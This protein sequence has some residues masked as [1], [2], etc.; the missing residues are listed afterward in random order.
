MNN[1]TIDIDDMINNIFTNE[2]QDIKSI[3]LSFDV[4]DEYELFKILVDILTHGLKILFGDEN[5]K[6]DINTITETDFKTIEKYFNSFGFDI[7]YK[8]DIP[9]DK[10]NIDENTE[11]PSLDDSNTENEDDGK[12]QL[13][14]YYFT[15]K[16]DN[17]KYEIS[18]DYL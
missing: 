9:L 16:T 12:N 1:I 5:D 18:F 14:L 6:V 8:Y 2:P 17:I 4:T 15:L 7:K 11:L 10:L 3:Q 13:R